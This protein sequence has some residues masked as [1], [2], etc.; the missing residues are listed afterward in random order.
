M[1]KYLGKR[2]LQMFITL[3]MFQAVTYFLMDAQPGDIADLLT[4]NPDIPPAERERIRQDLGLDRPPL[5][6]FLKYVGNFYQGD[7][8]VSFSFF[9]RPVT[10]IIKE[11]LPRTLVLFVTA[12]IIS[13]V[14]GYVTGKVLA[15]KRGGFVEYSSTL[16]GVILYTVF[17]PWF[18]LMMIWLFAVYLDW[19]PAGKFLDPILWLD[20]PEGVHANDLFIRMI[21]SALIASVVMVIGL[22]LTPRLSRNLRNVG[23]WASFII[24]VI[25]LILY[26][27]LVVSGLTVFAADIL[28]HLILPVLTVTLIAYG[29]TMLLMRTSM[30]E[31]LREDYILTARAKGLPDKVVRDKH[32]ARNALL[33]VWTGLVFSI[34]NSLS[35]GI[36][37]ETIFSW[38][39]LGLTLLNAA[40]VEDI[41]L[42]MGALTVTGLMT[43]MS[44]LVA[45][46][47]YAF[48]DPRIRYH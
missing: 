43:L 18:A 37:T 25:G 39:G 13:F 7:L 23:R 30:L 8:G 19:L 2:L 32:A 36:I 22:V 48:L 16:V 3:L 33:P 17:T 42:A 9:P 14:A 24:P 35:G 27:Q 44:H 26:W 11:R 15:W 21:M 31:T 12:S 47:G 29:G 34:G 20:A 40:Q 46:V 6:R 41:P 5:E 1:W 4:L 28:Q 45:D 38:P 10:D